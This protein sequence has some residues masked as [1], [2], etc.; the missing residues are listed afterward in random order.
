MTNNE[1]RPQIKLPEPVVLPDITDPV[2]YAALLKKA[3]QDMK[4]TRRIRRNYALRQIFM[5]WSS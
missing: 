4:E 2:V 1:Q 5:P 3:E